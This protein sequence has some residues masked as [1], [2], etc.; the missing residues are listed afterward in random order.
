MLTEGETVAVILAILGIGLA[1]F[2]PFVIE[3]LKK[4]RLIIQIDEDLIIPGQSTRYLHGRVINQPHLDILSAI[5]RHPA[6]DTRVKLRFYANNQPILEPLETKWTQAPECRTPITQ[7]V[8]NQSPNQ[9]EIRNIDAFDA[10][11]TVFSSRRTIPSNTR[12]EPFDV[13]VKNQGQIDCFPVT[14]WSYRFSDLADPNLAIH[15]GIFTLEIEAISTN[16]RSQTQTFRLRNEGPDIRDV[17]L[18]DVDL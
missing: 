14:G 16:A 12:G 10:T 15:N 18:H 17:E 1:I 7:I 5:E 13:I 8:I 3:R 11:K 6:Y 2:V 9:V 4:P